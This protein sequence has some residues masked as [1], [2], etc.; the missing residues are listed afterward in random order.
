[1][2]NIEYLLDKITVLG[3]YADERP[4]IKG[5]NMK[6]ELGSWRFILCA[7][8]SIDALVK[9]IR[10]QQDAMTKYLGQSYREEDGGVARVGDDMERAI[11]ES[12][13][14]AKGVL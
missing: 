4:I 3:K 12:E 8:N 2:T 1:M 9:I 10:I 13:N 11:Q 6:N 14:I 7:V 5:Q